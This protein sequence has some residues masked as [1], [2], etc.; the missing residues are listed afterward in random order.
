MNMKYTRIQKKKSRV[1][2][3]FKKSK[4]NK[5]KKFLIES[6]LSHFY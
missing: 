2:I 4:I 5:I 6:S 1:L 3:T